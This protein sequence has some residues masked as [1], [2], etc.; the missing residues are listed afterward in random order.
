MPPPP[1]LVP[2]VPLIDAVNP[3]LVRLGKLVETTFGFYYDEMCTGCGLCEQVCLAQKV[4]MADGRPVWQEAVQCLGCFACL[5]YC[6]EESIQIESKWYLRSYTEKNGR[7]HHPQIT[8]NDIA[9][10]KAI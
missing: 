10:Q 6:P 4:Q 8:A 5:N 9:G 1:F 2:L 3:L 7:Y